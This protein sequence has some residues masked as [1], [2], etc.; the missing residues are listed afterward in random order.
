VESYQSRCRPTLLKN[1]MARRNNVEYWCA[2]SAK[3]AWRYQGGCGWRWGGGMA[4]TIVNTI[5]VGQL[6]VDIGDARTDKL[7]W[8][9]SAS[10]TLSNDPQKNQKKI[11]SAL[12]KMFRNFPPQP[13]K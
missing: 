11:E 4:T 7:L 6:T 10:G 3:L 1:A 12:D 8:M 13:K 5:P 2:S 9:G